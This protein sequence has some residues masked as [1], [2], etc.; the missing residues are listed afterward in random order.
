MDVIPWTREFLMERRGRYRVKI[1]VDAKVKEILDDG[2]V[3]STNGGEESIRGVDTIVLAMGAK[4]V[5]DLSNQISDKVAEIYVIG[6]ALKPRQAIE[7]IAEGAEVGR[8]I[9]ARHEG[10]GERRRL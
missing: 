3:L 4:S 7:A 8:R 10:K 6:D 2:V 1:R 9:E 5:D